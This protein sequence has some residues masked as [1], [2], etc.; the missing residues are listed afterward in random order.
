MGCARTGI[1]VA[2]FEQAPDILDIGAAVGLECAAVNALSSLGL[3]EGLRKISSVPWRRLRVM[4]HDGKQLALWPRFDASVAVHRAERV[5]RLRE[6]IGDD[7]SLAF[8]SA[9][10]PRVPSNTGVVR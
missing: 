3:G 8:R 4:R 7:T 6:G 10:L 9:M 5:Q 2:V 1:E